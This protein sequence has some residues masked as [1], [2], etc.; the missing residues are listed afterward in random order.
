LK[1]TARSRTSPAPRSGTRASRSPWLTRPAAAARR[2]TGAGAPDQGEEEQQRDG[3]EADDR[4]HLGARGRAGRVVAQSRL[5]DRLA[6]EQ[7]G[8]EVPHRVDLPL[9]DR[10][11]DDVP[12][13]L[14][15]PSGQRQ[16]LLLID[17]GVAVDPPEEAAQDH[18]V[19]AL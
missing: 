19:A 14:Q 17:V 7:L 9:P 2:R 15:V 8:E 18:P 3:D 1:P 5:L 13:R 10:G 12:R 6:A 11:R 4:D 16:G